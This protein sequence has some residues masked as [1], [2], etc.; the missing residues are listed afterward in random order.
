MFT[1]PRSIGMG[2]TNLVRPRLSLLDPGQIDQ[3][4]QYALR[5]LSETGVRVDS[6][7]V[8]EL[9]KRKLGAASVQ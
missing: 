7:P 8:R 9:L 5:I 4:H 2:Q 3:V 6:A 1:D